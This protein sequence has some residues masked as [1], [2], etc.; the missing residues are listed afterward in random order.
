MAFFG[1]SGKI[2]RYDSSALL[3][4]LKKEQLNETDFL[5]CYYVMYD[6]VKVYVEYSLTQNF[7]EVRPYDKLTF[8]ELNGYLTQQ[9]CGFI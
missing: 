8:L 1:K 3:T 9:D 2:H 6:G 5:F 7:E 4:R